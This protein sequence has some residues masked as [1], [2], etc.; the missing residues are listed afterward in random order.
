MTVCLAGDG[1]IVRARV[2][3][4][5]VAIPSYIEHQLRI[6]PADHEELNAT[7]RLI[8]E[9]FRLQVYADIASRLQAA[10]LE[11]EDKVLATRAR[12][13]TLKVLDAAMK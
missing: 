7:E 4:T 3:T 1:N 13:A 11:L 8:E 6:K 12:D 9:Q 2:H 10:L 5:G